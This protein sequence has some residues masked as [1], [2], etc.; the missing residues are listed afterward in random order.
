LL[1][2][3]EVRRARNAEDWVRRMQTVC[4]SPLAM[5][6]AWGD[7][8]KPWTF[9]E[10]EPIIR[11]YIK[12]R[13]RLMPYFYTAFARYRED[14]IPPFRAMPFVVSP[15]ELARAE[16]LQLSMPTLNTVEGAYGK[17]KAPQWD[18]Q[19]MIGDSM[20]VAPLVEGETERDVLLPAGSWIGFEDGERYEGGG[21]IRVRVGL[22]TI[23]V[24]VRDGAVIPMTAALP[25]TLKPGEQSSLE[26]VHFGT[27]EGESW[28][29]D[30]DGVTLDYEHEACGWW[31]AV[32]KKTEDGGYKGDLLGPTELP[33]SYSSVKWSFAN[34]GLNSH[35]E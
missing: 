7:G 13:M 8:T 2:S 16:K 15:E 30:D 20:L 9:P 3:P 1:W 32:V 31:K 35:D 34:M 4:F 17:Q 11:R 22:E 23:P 28:L 25:H 19:Y 27:A 18:D 12:L 21:V 29:Y 33:D 6:N 24:F 14:G 10:A 5:L 26:L